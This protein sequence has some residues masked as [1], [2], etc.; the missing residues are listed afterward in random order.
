MALKD[1]HDKRKFD[2]TSEPK[3]KTKKSKDKLIF[4]IQRHA[5]SRLHY[6]FRLEMEGVLKSWAVPKGPSLDPKDKRLAMMVED[7]PYD[8]K[9]FEGNIP[10]G[11]YGAGQVEVWDSGTYEPLEKNTKLSHEKELLKELHAGSLKFILHGKKLK[12]EFALVKMKNTDDNAWLLIKHKDEFA[13][14]PY[15]AEE[16]TSPKSL[17]TQFLE[18]KKSLK[19]KE[20]KKS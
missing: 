8:Y 9:D 1:Y 7:H 13:E 12:G 18:E 11:N 14:S 10:E 17:V 19:I 15:D 20:K 2:E 6:D 3:G 16:N 5:A 4:V